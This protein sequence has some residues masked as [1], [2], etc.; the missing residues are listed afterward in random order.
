MSDVADDHLMTAF[1]L[2]LRSNRMLFRGTCDVHAC[3]SRI[4][5]DLGVLQHLKPSPQATAGGLDRGPAPP[6][7]APWPVSSVPGHT[8]EPPAAC[9]AGPSAQAR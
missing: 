6:M 9:R 7:S 5:S 4:G 2:S 8:E 3:R 1:R